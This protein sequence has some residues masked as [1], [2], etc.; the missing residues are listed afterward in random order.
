MSLIRNVQCSAKHEAIVRDYSREG[1]I[2]KTKREFM[3]FVAVI[4][5][6]CQKRVKL[7]EAK[8]LAV[9][10]RPFGN[11][12]EAVDLLCMLAIAERGDM[13]A[14]ADE[15]KMKNND[16]MTIFEEYAAAGLEILNNEIK[17]H[18]GL[19][20]DRVLEKYLIDEFKSGDEDGDDEGDENNTIF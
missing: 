11:E 17:Q 15:E 6:H 20:L 8:E 16:A 19:G 5:F 3:C 2:F 1:G 9:D 18:P 10:A 12:K 7:T 13:S 4:G 14:L